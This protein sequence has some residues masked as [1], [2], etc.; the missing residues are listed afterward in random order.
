M[1]DY[2]KIQ[3]LKSKVVKLDFKGKPCYIKENDSL[4]EIIGERLC[5]LLNIQCAHYEPFLIDNTYYVVSPDL[6][7]EGTFILAKEFLS[8]S[9]NNIPSIINFFKNNLPS[10]VEELIVD[11]LKVFLFDTLFSNNDRFT[12]NWGL[13]K[14]KSSCFRQ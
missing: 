1:S 12:E 9:E 10:K 6:N 11:I 8:E 7:M 2:E 4:T 5:L 14:W 3:I 13:V